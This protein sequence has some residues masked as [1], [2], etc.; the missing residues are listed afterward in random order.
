MLEGLLITVVGMAVVFVV[1][2]ILMYVIMG[3]ERLFR[4]KGVAEVV[5]EKVCLL[6]TSPSP[7][8]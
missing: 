3:L 8:D 1:L 6:Y 2:A 4:E 7:R 5:S